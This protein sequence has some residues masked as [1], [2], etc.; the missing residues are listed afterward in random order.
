[1]V[2]SATIILGSESEMS[3]PEKTPARPQ[4]PQYAAVVALLKVNANFE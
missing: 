1:M 4:I 2:F 3:T